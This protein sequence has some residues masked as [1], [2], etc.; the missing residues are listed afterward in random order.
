MKPELFDQLTMSLKEA[1]D[2]QNGATKPTKVTTY[3]MPDVKTIR[4]SLGVTQAEFAKGLA[5]S[6]ETIKSWEQ[7]KRTNPSGLSR[8][9][10]IAIERNPQIF[11]ALAN[12]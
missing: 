8:K 4:A 9:V 11:H 1:I 12:A 6:T 3:E 7:G 10:L 5:M 2:I